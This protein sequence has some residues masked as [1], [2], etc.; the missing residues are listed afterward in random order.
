[1]SGQG[2]IPDDLFEAIIDAGPPWARYYANERIRSSAPRPRLIPPGEPIPPCLDAGTI[3]DD[4][5]LWESDLVRMPRE[6]VAAIDDLF[7]HLPAGVQV[8]STPPESGV[9]FVVRHARPSVTTL[10]EPS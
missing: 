3:A 4:L 9:A 2:W 1:M 5:E 7:R 6:E 10:P 8:W